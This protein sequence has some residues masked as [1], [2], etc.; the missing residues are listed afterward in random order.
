MSL[1]FAL[2]TASISVA[3]SAQAAPPKSQQPASQQPAF[4]TAPVTPPMVLAAMDICSTQMRAGTF[5]AQ[6]LTGSGW[7]L[8]IRSEGDPVLRGYRH[9]DNMII[10][11]TFDSAAGSDKCTVM[12]PT[13]MGLSFDS[14]RAAL[15]ERLN[16]RSRRSG[17][18]HS[19]A[20]DRLTYT[21]RPL[22]DAGVAIDIELQ[23]R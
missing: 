19:W 9:P 14:M 8:A 5:D 20:A 16:A 1:L 23:E 12:A 2:L 22:A 3:S 15:A 18:A 17:A 7:V 11:T 21:L 13:R 4:A 6:A 10:L